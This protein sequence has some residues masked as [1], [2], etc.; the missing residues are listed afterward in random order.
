MK[1]RNMKEDRIETSK[2]DGKKVETKKN[3]KR[4][5]GLDRVSIKSF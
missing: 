4:K 5:K 1:G 3:Q 2:R